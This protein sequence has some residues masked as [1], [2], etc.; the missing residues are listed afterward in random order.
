MP[1]NKYHPIIPGRYR[2]R[3]EKGETWSKPD[4]TYSTIKVYYY[5]H[6]AFTYRKEFNTITPV[7]TLLQRVEVVGIS[8]AARIRKLGTF[9]RV[10]AKV[11]SSDARVTAPLY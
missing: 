6:A 4:Y 9:T 10:R 3:V 8:S 11:V 1:H 5:Q 7:Y 2:S